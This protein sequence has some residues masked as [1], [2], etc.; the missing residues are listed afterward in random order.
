MKKIEKA[1][2]ATGT[3]IRD[4]IRDVANPP[5]EEV[6]DIGEALK[7]IHAGQEINYQ[8]AS[9]ELTFDE[10]GDVFGA[11]AEFSFADNGSIE[12]GESIELEGPVAMLTPG[13]SPAITPTSTLA[14]TSTPA[15][16]ATTPTPTPPG[17]EAVLAITGILAVASL[18]LRRRRT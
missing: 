12:F 10:N 17:F 13:P 1:G 4:N 11:Y 9:G 14:P 15:S 7:L 8:G 3:A 18:V 6:P 5:G 2:T 16:V